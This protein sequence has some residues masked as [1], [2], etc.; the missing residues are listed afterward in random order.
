MEHDYLET[1]QQSK[2]EVVLTMRWSA[3]N[4]LVDA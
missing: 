1:F 4:M 2:H 3:Q